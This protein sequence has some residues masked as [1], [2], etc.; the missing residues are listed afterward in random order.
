M[1]IKE[2]NELNGEQGLQAKIMVAMIGLFSEIE[3]DLI[4]ERTKEGLAVA[5]AK[6]KVLGVT[7]N[8]LLR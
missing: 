5:K 2:S 7:C 1:A 4:S 3:R 8:P 6:G